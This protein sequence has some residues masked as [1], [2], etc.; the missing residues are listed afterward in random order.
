MWKTKF[1]LSNKQFSSVGK[2]YYYCTI[3]VYHVEKRYLHW[4]SKNHVDRFQKNKENFFL[5]FT[6][7]RKQKIPSQKIRF[8][9]HRFLLVHCICIALLRFAIQLK[10]IAKSIYIK[11]NICRTTLFLLNMVK[12]SIVPKTE[13]TRHG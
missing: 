6:T 8:E 9:K 1:I 10:A 12:T 2:R 5:K 13:K 4:S 3:N 11:R 7:Q